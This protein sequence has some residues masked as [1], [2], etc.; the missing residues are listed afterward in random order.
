MNNKHLQRIIYEYIYHP[1]S[2]KQELLIKTREILRD[3]ELYMNS[4][5]YY[6]CFDYNR[7]K[8]YYRKSRIIG[9]KEGWFIR[10]FPIE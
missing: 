8:K 10:D 2:F 1:I 5:N 9:N 7:E 4:D 3:T 6:R